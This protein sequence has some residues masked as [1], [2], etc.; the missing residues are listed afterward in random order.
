M[1]LRYT[2]KALEDL[3]CLEEYI[4]INL[5]NPDAVKHVLAN[6]LKACSRLKEQP[7]IDL[8]LSQKTGRDT[9]MR[10]I[11]CGKYLAFYL[12]E[13]QMISII[14]ILDSRTNYMKIVFNEMD[15]K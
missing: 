1:K 10:Y 5:C 2:P 3:R 7:D 11:I 9:K 14:R 13:A 4:T 12:I 6:I 15:S 8:S